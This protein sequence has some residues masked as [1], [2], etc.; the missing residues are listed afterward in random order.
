MKSLFCAS[1]SACAC[2]VICSPNVMAQSTVTINGLVDIGV[3]RASN[4]WNVGS[5]QRSNIAFKGSEDLGDGLA[6]IFRLSTRFSP[7]T[8]TTES[9]PDK[10]FWHGEST[11]GLRGSFGTVRFGRALEAINDANGDFD[12]WGYFDQ[13]ASAPWD[14]W[15]YNWPSDPKANSGKPDYGRLNNGIF[16]D[17]PEWGPVQIHISGSPEKRDGDKRRSLSGAM[18]YNQG[19]L[20]AMVGIGR[21][22]ND[23][24]DTFLGLRGNFGSFSLMGA[25][26]HSVS[27]DSTAKVVT[28]GAEYRLNAF[29]FKANYGQLDLDGVKFEK[30]AGAGASYQLSKRTRV[31]ADFG[32]REFVSS[33]NNSYGVGL[34]HRF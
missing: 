21:N 26:D 29:T 4:V 22:S 24:K 10:P 34:A 23:D 28:V 19:P 7:D 33:S 31:Y 14:M 11:V 32:H 16:Y 17:S 18:N 9:A 1:A 27:G 13:I 20:Q 5:I 8:G 2:L 15:Q 12:P 30:L 25:Y 6:A 3:Y